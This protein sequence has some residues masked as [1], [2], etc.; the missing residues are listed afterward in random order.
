MNNDAFRA[1][2]NQK[3]KPSATEK[4]TK[5]IAREAVENEFKRRRAGGGAR[6]GRGGYDD[7][8][9]SSDED[10]SR[11][12][13]R[14][15]KDAGKEE[16]QDVPDWKRRRREK[17]LKDGGGGET[18]EYR[19]RA[20]ERREG[21]NL[22]YVELKGLTQ[23]GQGDRKKEL[24]LSKYLGGDEEHTHLVKGL[25]KALAEKV[26]REEMA[27]G[28]A[29]ES[30]DLDELLEN[31]YARRQGNN[32]PHKA[33]G[34][35]NAAPSSELGK[36]VFD[37]LLQKETRDTQIKSNPTLQKSIQRSILTFSL[38]ADVRNRKLAW[39]VPRI[40]FFSGNPDTAQH[41]LSEHMIST[42]TKKL[43][44]K[45]DEG[46]SK[47]NGEGKYGTDTHRVTS[48]GDR[49]SAEAKKTIRADRKSNSDDSD[50]D[51]FENA[52]TYEVSLK[53]AAK[54]SSD[55]TGNPSVADKQTKQSIFKHLL[56]DAPRPKPN[57]RLQQHN[58]HHLSRKNKK[59]IERDLIGG[60]D[61]HISSSQTLYSK[62]RGPTSAAIEGMSMS[63]QGGYG[64]D[65]DVDFGGL[66]D[67]KRKDQKKKTN[68]NCEDNAKSK[69]SD[70]EN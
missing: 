6:R 31:A 43:D 48:I 66:E 22:D 55:A 65:M 33:H 63:Y 28:E 11:Q 5:E 20:K 47:V 21:N 27:Q 4:T 51:I 50:D 19:D 46:L 24:E 35:R 56:P 60:Q 32:R 42:I 29:A 26:R 7:S 2:V 17:R 41:Q 23:S 52:G 59:V 30:G 67:S 58:L 38:D 18:S 70:E 16:D 54:V 64:E 10:T 14:K 15:E 62:R 49:P 69:S 45:I 1:L 3:R 40:S 13:L 9:G 12:N 8:D 57:T 36:S 53:T 25:D 68:S 61:Q 37:Y 34:W 44:G 39:E